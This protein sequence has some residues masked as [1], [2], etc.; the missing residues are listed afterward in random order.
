MFAALQL[1]A[2]NCPKLQT[3]DVAY[4]NQITFDAAVF[5][6]SRCP[7][8]RYMGLMRCDQI[9]DTEAEMLVEKF[10]QV[11]YSTMWLDCKR[12]LEKAREQGFIVPDKRGFC[13]SHKA[14]VQSSS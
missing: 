3:L 6:S 7:H 2:A 8:L 14:M 4:C 11:H 13:E 9:T 5:I 1:L 10:P 12:V